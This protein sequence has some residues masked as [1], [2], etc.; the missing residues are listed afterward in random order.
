MGETQRPVP[1]VHR[2]IQVVLWV[3]TSCLSVALIPGAHLTCHLSFLLRGPPRYPLAGAGPWQSSSPSRAG[4]GV[5]NA[6]TSGPPGP[7]LWPISLAGWKG[8]GLHWGLWQQPLLPSICRGSRN[9]PPSLQ[10]PTEASPEPALGKWEPG[11]GGLGS[12]SPQMRH[13]A[14]VASGWT[15]LISAHKGP[16]LLPQTPDTALLAPA[17]K[18]QA[19]AT[20]GAAASR[21]T[22]LN[23]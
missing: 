16:E 11:E 18:R 6:M 15:P 8:L 9:R 1:G 22:G 7:W 23:P 4:I 14:D 17:A 10:V 19:G 20:A 21:V 5:L 12:S 13:A 2:I 3:A